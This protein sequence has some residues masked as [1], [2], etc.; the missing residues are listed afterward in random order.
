MWGQSLQMPSRSW[1]F[2]L[3]FLHAAPAPAQPVKARVGASQKMCKTEKES[4]LR[5][6]LFHLFFES[7][8]RAGAAAGPQTLRFARIC[9]GERYNNA[10]RAEVT[11]DSIIDCSS[12]ISVGGYKLITSITLLRFLG[13]SP[14]STPKCRCSRDR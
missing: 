14:G 1:T 9:G 4:S 3:F 8:V 11:S 5:S 7:S 12:A 13:A 6:I 2:F 10:P